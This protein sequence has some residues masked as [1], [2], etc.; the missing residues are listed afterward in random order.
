MIGMSSFFGRIFSGGGC[1]VVTT[2]GAGTVVS[3]VV[4]V[5]VV[6]GVGIPLQRLASVPHLDPN[7]EG[8]HKY[9]IR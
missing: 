5:V 6:F 2:N 4:V 8:K 7:A 1:S 9:V 3:G